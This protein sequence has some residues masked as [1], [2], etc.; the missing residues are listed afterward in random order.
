MIHPLI[1]PTPH[2]I[3]RAGRGR[4]RAIAILTGLL[5]VAVVCG[6]CGQRGSGD[7]GS[8]RAIRVER[9]PQGTEIELNPGAAQRNLDQAGRDLQRSADQAGRS[10]E[11]G[12]REVGA[13]LA[14]AARQAGDALKQ[15]AREVGDKVGPTVRRAAADAA[16]TAKVQAKL[17]ADPEIKALKIDVSTVDGVV[18]LGGRVGTAEEKAAAERVALHTDGVQRVVNALEVGA[19]D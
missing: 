16:L 5:A 9:G 3:G 8:G 14:P 10:L 6:A 13:Q 18:T 4:S 11:R 12:A 19:T 1:H 17:L 7:G 15:G 2:L